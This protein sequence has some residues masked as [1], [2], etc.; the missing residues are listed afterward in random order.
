MVVTLISFF[1]FQV[2]AAIFLTARALGRAV[3]EFLE[4]DLFD[5]GRVRPIAMFGLRVA[6]LFAG[7]NALTVLAPAI[8]GVAPRAAF[9]VLGTM[10]VLVVAAGIWLSTGGLVRRMRKAKRA[11]Q[12]RVARA[13]QGDSEALTG[14]PVVNRLGHL[15]FLDLLSYRERVDALPVWPFDASM[16]GRLLVYAILPPLSWVAGALVEQLLGHLMSS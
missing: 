11:E 3:E 14:S 15:S 9:G 8:A 12:E 16:L 6:F 5:Q 7:I 4:L 2:L 13:I 10:N 1:T